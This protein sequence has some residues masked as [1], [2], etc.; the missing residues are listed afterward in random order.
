MSKAAELAALIGS[1]TALS[2][3]NLI[4][5]GAMQV[6]QRGTAAT[7]VSGAGV[8]DTVD[9]FKLF[10]FTDGAFTS[11]RST[12]VP[13]GE[14]FGYSL[15]LAVTTA[16]TSIAATQ[17]AVFA[18]I[19]EAQNLQHLS[20]GTSGAKALTLSF[21]VRSSKTGTY[22]I[23]LEKNDST[24]YRYI[25]EYSIS[26]SDTWE[27]KTIT[28]QPD[29]QIKA[30]GGAIA[31]DNGQGFRLLFNL[32]WGSTYSGA[33][34]GV[35]SSGSNDYSTSNQVNWMDSDSN[36]FYITGVKLEVGD[37]AT[38]FQHESYAEN[39]AKCQRY[40]QTSV[41]NSHAGLYTGSTYVGDV[42]FKGT[43]R[44]VPTLSNLTGNYGNTSDIRADKFHFARNS[45]ATYLDTWSA[46]AEL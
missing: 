17:Y 16:D 46:D 13:S 39:L 4:I 9:R 24:R 38:P 21:W 31:N 15:K 30:S 6:A 45:A 23:T 25:K 12:T 5:N 22:T 19:I 42:F 44:D 2:N 41:A 11:E 7:T 37:S 28:I 43:M 32:A 35:W 29:S 20:Y 34:D 3:R 36:D 1:Q 27:K 8:Y 33:T 18:Q 26:T 10:D 40:F 14:G